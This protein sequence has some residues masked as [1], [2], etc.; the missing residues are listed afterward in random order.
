MIKRT[1]KQVI[2]KIISGYV[3]AACNNSLS[4]DA[5][6]Q[7]VLHTGKKVYLCMCYEARYTF[8]AVWWKWLS[9]LQTKNI[10]S[11]DRNNLK[12]NNL[13]EE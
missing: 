3:D 13:L 10:Q 7:F 4:S 6:T 11:L 1:S 9:H 2:P 12:E 8:F 5:Y